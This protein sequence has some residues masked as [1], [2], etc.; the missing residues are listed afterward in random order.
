MK[1]C[2]LALLLALTALT[3]RAEIPIQS[4]NTPNGTRVFFVET[5]TLPM[6]DV[7]IDF[8]A[9]TARDPAAQTGVAE[10][11]HALLDAG[12]GT[13]RHALDE[14]TIADRFADV[15][16][17]IN[18]SVDA[19]RAS[20]A[21]RVL[22]SEPERNGAL[23]IF[24]QI[25]AHP[26]FPTKVLERER[27]RAI[28]S[29]REAQTQPAAI[30]SENFAHLA[31]G[32]HPYGRT[33]EEGDLKR[34]TRQM[35]VDFHHSRYTAKAASITLVGDLSREQAETIAHDLVADLPTGSVPAPLPAVTAPVARTLHIPHPASQAHIAIGMPTL[36]RGDPDTMALVVGNYTL[37]GGGFNSRLMAELRSARGLTYG[38][39]SYF[40]PQAAQGVFMIGLETKAEQAGEAIKAVNQTLD[41]FL[42]EG[43]TEVELQAAKDNLINGFAL[44]LDNNQKILEQ[45]ASLGFYGL[46]LNSLDTYSERVQSVTLA[47]I[48]AAFARHVKT[49][50]LVTV[51]VG[52]K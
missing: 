3:A 8:A 49:E 10:M 39:Y 34:L 18:G 1:H 35:L 25:L 51:Y 36:Q 30:L 43:P 11:T 13:G 52:G 48:R 23:A 40:A 5:H 7:R 16:A 46:P 28:A 21:L 14:N 38:V 12:V 9:G 26:Q 29:L 15:G 22:S 2:M 6:L 42:K 44:H 17:Q 19:D 41:G 50:N 4:W 45:V 33:T 47:Q 32:S 31:Y 20:V 27:A 37:G 24:R